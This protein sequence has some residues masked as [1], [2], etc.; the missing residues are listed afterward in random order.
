MLRLLDKR[1]SY[2]PLQYPWALK[3]W[4]EHEKMHWL[5]HEV[6]LRDD[7]V[8][9]KSSLS[10]PQKEFLTQIFRFFTQADVSVADGYVSKFMPY[11]NGHPEITMMMASFAA[12]EAV[13][14]EAYALLTDTIG[15]PESEYSAFLDY[16][17]MKDKYEFLDTINL[18]DTFST[19]KALAVYSAFTEGMQLYSS[20]AMLMHFERLGKMRGMTNIVRWSLRDEDKHATSMIQL[21][22][23]FVSEYL[24]FD[25]YSILEYEVREVARVMVGL[26]DKFIDLAFSMCDE[27]ALNAGL[28]SSEEPLTSALLKKY[29]RHITDY[30]LGQMGYAPEYGETVNP[31][32]W[33]D[34]LLI[35]PEHTNFFENKPTEYSKAGLEGDMF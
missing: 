6:S 27:H 17:A 15:M 20:F 2:K 31:L 28:P 16:A 5:S 33:L 30:R 35:A 34:R 19:A 23:T 24:P 21:L 14:I 1:I 13:H 26:E 32:K 10:E 11:F 18:D 25:E 29:I 8:D 22:R 12:R 3:A 7:V 4:E 9:W